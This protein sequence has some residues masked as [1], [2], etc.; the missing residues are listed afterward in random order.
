VLC[1]RKQTQHW[2]LSQTKTSEFDC[3]IVLSH[4]DAGEG[5]V[6]LHI[7]PRRRIYIHL[8]SILPSSG[9]FL[10]PKAVRNLAPGWDRIKP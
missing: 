9:Q 1:P 10:G 4:K 5:A 8:G 6:P 7:N 3:G 2:G